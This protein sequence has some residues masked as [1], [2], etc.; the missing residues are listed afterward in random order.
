MP[1]TEENI[2]GGIRRGLAG[3]SDIR[4]IQYEGIRQRREA[5]AERRLQDEATR[6]AEEE[7][8]KKLEDEAAG[9]ALGSMNAAVSKILSQPGTYRDQAGRRVIREEVWDGQIEPILG[10]MAGISTE[11]WKGIEH[12]NSIRLSTAHRQAQ[13]ENTAGF[14]DFETHAK[15]LSDAF[16]Y[17][18]GRQ[19]FPPEKAALERQ[20]KIELTPERSGATMSPAEKKQMVLDWGFPEEQANLIALGVKPV[21]PEQKLL[22]TVIKLQQSGTLHIDQDPF[23]EAQKLLTGV[24]I[25]LSPKTPAPRRKSADA[26]LQAMGA[27]TKETPQATTAAAPVSAKAPPTTQV[28]TGTVQAPTTPTFNSFEDAQSFL[29]NKLAADQDSVYYQKVLSAAGRRLPK[30]TKK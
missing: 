23:E 18:H 20:A 19:P 2:F 25:A 5:G 24:R 15:T 28:E 21:D 13:P 9:K 26:D 16:V 8:T 1:G 7:V 10:Q 30:R 29:K 14:S 3:F 4:K 11:N 6:K 12:V 22:D 17:K 27:Q